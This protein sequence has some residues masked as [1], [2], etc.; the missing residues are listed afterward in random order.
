MSADDFTGDPEQLLLK[1]HEKVDFL[2]AQ[3][4]TMRRKGLALPKTDPA[5]GMPVGNDL[6][7]TAGTSITCGTTYLL[8][9]IS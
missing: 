7:D 1:Y 8:R 6:D 4:H 5:Y 9:A 3:M 2:V